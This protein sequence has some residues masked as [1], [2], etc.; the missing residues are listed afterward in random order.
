MTV[1]ALASSMR[2]AGVRVHVAPSLAEAVSQ[3]AALAR[4]GD[5]VITLGAGSVGTVPPRLLEQL[6][7]H[8]GSRA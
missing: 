4:A 6:A 7:A 2:R 5:A 3:V 8:A 1:E